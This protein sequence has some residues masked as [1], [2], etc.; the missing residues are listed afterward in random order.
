VQGLLIE[1]Y[2]HLTYTSFYN[3]VPLI[4]NNHSTVHYTRVDPCDSN[5]FASV[6]KILSQSHQPRPYYIMRILREFHEQ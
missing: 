2:D 3:S 6:V 1:N 5:R 4:K